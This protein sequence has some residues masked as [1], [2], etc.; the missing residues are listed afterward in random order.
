MI[1]YEFLKKLNQ[2]I[3]LGEINSPVFFHK[4]NGHIMPVVL[5]MKLQAEPFEAGIKVT[6]EEISGYLYWNVETGN[7]ERIEISEEE[8]DKLGVPL[9]YIFPE[10]EMA[11]EIVED[12]N[13]FLSVEMVR[14]ALE[15]GCLNQ[16]MTDNYLK[17][18]YGGT[19][20]EEL[21]ELYGY[22][23]PETYEGFFNR[24]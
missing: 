5:C 9:V 23:F 6:V 15:A 20:S 18:V 24:G 21:K 17:S 1:S 8:Q 12:D 10:E 16:Y 4:I 11:P 19:I 3:M 22:F 7:V 14:C 13:Y 2:H